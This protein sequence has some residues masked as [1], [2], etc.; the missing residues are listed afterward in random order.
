MA[1]R[2]F[3]ITIQVAGLLPSRL[4]HQAIACLVSINWSSGVRFTDDTKDGYLS[5]MGSIVDDQWQIKC[6]RRRS[7]PC[8]LTFDRSPVALR[9]GSNMSP[10]RS[11]PRRGLQHNVVLQ[12]EI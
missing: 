10:S 3:L 6:D 4:T 5:K 7:Y 2:R 12:K 9:V 1:D 11:N 8:V